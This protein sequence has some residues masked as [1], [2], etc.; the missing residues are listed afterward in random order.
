MSYILDALR[1]A[2]A[3]RSRGGVPGLHAQA[4]GGDT[5]DEPRRHGAAPWAGIAIA[6][7]LTLLV[8]LLWLGF[9][10]TTPVPEPAPNVLPVVPPPAPV[11]APVVAAEP[12]APPAPAPAPVVPPATTLPALPPPTPVPVARAPAAKAEPAAPRAAASAPAAEPRIPALRELPEDLRRQIPPLNVGGSTWSANAAS[13]FVIL[14]GQLLREN[15]PVN[16]ELTLRQI[17]QR[18]LVLEFRGQRFEFGF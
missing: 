9:A 11:A 5:A 1:R 15:D 17:R 3:E 7:G 10:P 6:L 2:D 8:V 12:A 16:P 4:Q 14:N 18:S 13:R